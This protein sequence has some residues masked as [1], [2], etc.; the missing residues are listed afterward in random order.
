MNDR[1]ILVSGN[2][3]LLMA[4]CAPW[5]PLTCWAMPFCRNFAIYCSKPQPDVARGKGELVPAKLTL[6]P[7]T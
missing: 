5:L 6:K 2:F 7:A 3:N 4:T 1:L